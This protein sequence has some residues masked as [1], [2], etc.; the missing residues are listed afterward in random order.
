[1]E[2]MKKQDMKNR[3]CMKCST[4]IYVERSVHDDWEGVL[5]CNKCSHCI[6]RYRYTMSEK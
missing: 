6:T 5:H 3:P 4:G 2:M 1:M